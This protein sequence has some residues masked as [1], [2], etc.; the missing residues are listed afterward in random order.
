MAVESANDLAVFFDQDDFAVGCA[1]TRAG[2]GSADPTFYGIFDNEYVA[3]DIEGEAQ[4]ATTNPVFHCS[5]AKLPTGY[6]RGDTCVINATSYYVR[7]FHPDGTGTTLV[8][9][10]AQ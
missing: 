2:Q 5:T 9:L 8:I 7:N 3:L 6:A 4:V 10:E 1:W